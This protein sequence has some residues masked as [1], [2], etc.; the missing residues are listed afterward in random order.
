MALPPHHSGRCV[1][2]T[3]LRRIRKDAAISRRQLADILG[4]SQ[5]I[6]GRLERKPNK[7]LELLFAAA[8]ACGYEIRALR[9]DAAMTRER[10]QAATGENHET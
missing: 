9:V 10:V 8:R 2:G 6:I 3:F 1:A 7:R 4:V 5:E